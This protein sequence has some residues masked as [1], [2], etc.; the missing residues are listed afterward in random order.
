M[1]SFELLFTVGDT[2]WTTQMESATRLTAA[3]AA[4]VELQSVVAQER[5]V[6]ASV[7]VFEGVSN[8]G[9]VL[10]SWDYEGALHEFVWSPA[11][12]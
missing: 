3:A 7:T 8:E 10:G 1:A 5:P 12:E 2:V 11:E 4:R 9:A 6:T